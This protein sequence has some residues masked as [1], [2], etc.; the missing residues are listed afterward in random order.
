MDRKPQLFTP[1]S[2]WE[3]GVAMAVLVAVVVSYGAFLHSMETVVTLG[4]NPGFSGF[5]VEGQNPWQQTYVPGDD[6]GPLR[7]AATQR[8]RVPAFR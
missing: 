2:L 5:Y 8:A 1:T 6:T 7:T 4:D 3:A